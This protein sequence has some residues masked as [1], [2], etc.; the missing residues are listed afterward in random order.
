MDGS[1]SEQSVGNAS[2][3]RRSSGRGRRSDRSEPYSSERRSKRGGGD[4]PVVYDRAIKF[5]LNNAMAGSIIGTAG[6]AMKDLIEITNASIHI[7][8]STKRHPIT[9]DRVLFISGSDESVGLAQALV[10]EMIGQQTDAINTGLVGLVWN[11]AAARAAPGQ[12]DD[13]DVSCDI[14]IPAACAG[15]VLGR[16]GHVLRSM[17]TECDVEATM[18]PVEG[19]ELLQERIVSIKGTVGGCMRF[20][21]MLLTKMAESEEE[22]RFVHSG[23]AYPVALR[24]A[25][26]ELVNGHGNGRG[27]DRERGDRDRDRGHIVQHSNISIAPYSTVGNKRGSGDD[28]SFVRRTTSRRS[29]KWSRIALLMS[30]V[31]NNIYNLYMFTDNKSALQDVVSDDLTLSAFTTIELA[32]P[33]YCIGAV[34]GIKVSA[35]I[36][37]KVQL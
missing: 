11:P 28:N 10:W 19:S 27:R 3:S 13:V 33:N 15:R 18:S 31:L 24:E 5:L 23:T 22:S 14:A 34:L 8:S 4:A 16:G 32:V 6:F 7:S 20:T 35:A 17:K 36:Q 29:G 9:D 2:A 26:V 25:A 30:S 1:R 21:S 37:C 12:Y